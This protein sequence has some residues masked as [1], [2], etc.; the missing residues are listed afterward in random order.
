MP[1][2]KKAG[3]KRPRKNIRGA[4]FFGDL[5]DG[6]KSV[7]SKVIPFVAQNGLL[8]KGLSLIPHP[9][10][11]SAAKLA[12]AVGLGRKRRA[13]RKARGRGPISQL[14]GMFGLGA[15]PQM[16][17]GRKRGNMQLVGMNPSF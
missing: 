12:G 14:A 17:G 16:G 3:A 2:R 15:E 1:A 9:G 4:G 10:A 13:P 5:W 6:V 8:S 11:Q 7:G